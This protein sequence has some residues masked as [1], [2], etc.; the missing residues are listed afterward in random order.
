MI[1]RITHVSA[2]SSSELLFPESPK[3]PSSA[4][5]AKWGLQPEATHFHKAAEFTP[6]SV[7]VYAFMQSLANKNT[8]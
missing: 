3:E 4:E 7:D 1:G 5:L 2:D 6:G 8:S